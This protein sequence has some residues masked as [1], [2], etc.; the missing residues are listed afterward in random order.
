MNPRSVL[1]SAAINIGLAFVTLSLFSVLKKQPSNASVYYARPLSHRRQ[2]PVHSP[3]SPLRRF[4]PSVAWVFRAFNVTEAEILDAHGLD[5][6]VIIRLF[7]FGIKLFTV[8]SLVGLVVLLPVNYGVQEVQNGSSFT[9]DSLTISNVKIGSNRLWVHFTCLCFISFYGMFLLYKEYNE[10]LIRRIQQIQKLKHR[11]DQ[12]TVIVREIPLCIQHKARDCCV[13][14]FF[15]RHY[16]NTYYS[17]QMVYKTEDLEELVSQAKSLSKKIED[18]RESCMDNNSKSRL[19]LLGLLHQET[20]KA[21]LLEEKLQ[22]LS[23]KIHQLRSKDMLQKKE[24]PVAFV[25][26]KS[27][28]GAAAAAHLQQHSHPLLWITELAPEPRDVSWRNMRVSYRVVPLY[29]LGVVIAAS[30]LT[31]FFAIPVTAVQGIAKYEKLKKWF[32]PAMAVQ[33]IPGLSSV[34]TGFLPSV[35]LKAF[36]YIVPF[37]MFAMAKIAGCI[38]RSKEEIKACNMVFYF[39]V[40]NVFFWSVLSG[41]L[42]DLIGEFITQPKNIPSHLAG[43]VSAQADFFVTYILTDGLSGF[44]LELLQPGMLIWELLKSCVYGSQRERSPYLYS[45]PYFRIIPLVSLSVLIGI[46]YAVVAPL[47]LPF[48]IVYFCLGYVVFVNQITMIGLFGL[49]LKPAASISTIPLIMFTLMFNEYCKMR[50]LPS[51][52]HYSLLDAGESDELD[53]K[54]GLLE[55]HCKNAMNAYSPP[56]LRPVNFMA[57]ESSSTPL[58]SS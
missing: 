40:G 32:P 13:D 49:K 4:L 26:F 42:L 12:F 7:K 19:P 9:M 2:I 44:S 38:A 17:Y 39:L 15:S 50:F 34:V 8:C 24:L 33:F 21:A 58:I 43:A 18:T 16:P 56:G 57:S 51:F 5:A 55:L 31:V 27:R 25:T 14:H 47:L 35:V 22:A 45:F 29:G 23:H 48:L 11:P 52:H 1:A 41:S 20:S 28:S 6:L 37:T 54:C 10:I 53:E 3:S 36:I 30:L 46:V